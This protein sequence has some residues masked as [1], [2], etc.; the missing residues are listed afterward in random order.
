MAIA[1]ERIMNRVD[2][3]CPTSHISR[4]S[5]KCKWA[6]SGHRTSRTAHRI[7]PWREAGTEPKFP[8]LG[9]TGSK[10]TPAACAGPWGQP[11]GERRRSHDAPPSASWWWPPPLPPPPPPYGGGPELP[12]RARRRTLL[13][14]PA[15]RPKR[16][17]SQ[18]HLSAYSH[19][20]LTPLS[21][22]AAT[23]IQ[24]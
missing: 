1:S 6:T 3:T 8:H 13:D 2:S 18:S 10:G 17:Y 9:L 21:D 7:N 24:C 23:T 14:D 19:C 4:G 16:T 5:P 15:R 20:T 11:G 12:P 22:R